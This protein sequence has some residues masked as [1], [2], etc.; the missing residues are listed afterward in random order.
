MTF[1]IAQPNRWTWTDEEPTPYLLYELPGAT[2][3][4]EFQVQQSKYQDEMAEHME[5]R[6]DELDKMVD[7]LD[8]VDS[9]DELVEFVRDEHEDIDLEQ[10][11]LGV[12]LAEFRPSDAVLDAYLEFCLEHTVGLENIS[13][14]D[15]KLLEWDA[16]DLA[17]RI[18]G[19]ETCEGAQRRILESL[20][21]SGVECRQA[22]FA[23]GDAIAEGLDAEVKKN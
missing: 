4:N 8:D 15:G 6:G 13:G 21:S 9:V 14:P 12:M 20:G 5:S 16:P 2:A 17:E 10:A 11:R 3:Y 23:Y 7:G 19:A 1:Q 18:P 22:L